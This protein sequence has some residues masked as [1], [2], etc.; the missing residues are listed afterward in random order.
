MP[1]ANMKGAKPPFMSGM[2]GFVL[3][4]L[5]ERPSWIEMPGSRFTF[6]M[7]AFNSLSLG[8]AKPG[9]SVMKN[10]RSRSLP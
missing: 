9:T 10:W 4:V 1:P 6:P 3:L 2:K 8:A 5:K 7:R